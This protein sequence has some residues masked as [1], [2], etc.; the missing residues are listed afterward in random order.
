MSPT[1]ADLTGRLETGGESGGESV[2]SRGRGEESV[3]HDPFLRPLSP[4]NLLS[5]LRRKAD[6]S[7]P[8]SLWWKQ[9]R[10]G[11]NYGSGSSNDKSPHLCDEGQSSGTSTGLELEDWARGSVALPKS[12]SGVRSA[13]CVWWGHR[14]PQAAG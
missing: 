4:L 10:Y 8:N 7:P 9:S 3:N 5:S 6:S 14:L 13:K 1:H 12:S 11:N 2:E